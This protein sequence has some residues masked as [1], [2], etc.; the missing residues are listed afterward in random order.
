MLITISILSVIQVKANYLPQQQIRFQETFAPRAPIVTPFSFSPNVQEGQRLLQTCTTSSG[1]LPVTYN[2]LKDG[3]LIT[4]QVALLKKILITKTDD[5]LTLKISP[6]KLEHSGNYTCVATNNGGTHSHHSQLI[7]HAE[8]R[9]LKEPQHE[10]IVATRGQ[11]VVIDCQTTGWPRPIQSWLMK[12][13]YFFSPKSEPFPSSHGE[14]SI[15]ATV[16]ASL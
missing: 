4:T 16:F 1:D 9:W 3:Q 13:K 2:W 15:W 6:I 10:P 11:T 12:S 14:R 5:S 7:V 8:P